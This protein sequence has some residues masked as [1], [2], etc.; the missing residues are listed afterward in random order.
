MFGQIRFPY[1]ISVYHF[2]FGRY[3][4]R[5]I[6][7]PLNHQMIG[8]NIVKPSG[9]ELVCRESFLIPVHLIHIILCEF[10]I[11]TDYLILVIGTVKHDFYI[12]AR[13]LLIR[14]R[15]FNRLYSTAQFFHL[16][17]VS[18]RNAD[19]NPGKRA[20]TCVV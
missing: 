1:I 8:V 17:A 20:F 2:R 12:R 19:A 18:V 7:I 3:L 6:R 4:Y 9:N 10:K 5:L 15:I 16:F 11:E 13:L 14:I